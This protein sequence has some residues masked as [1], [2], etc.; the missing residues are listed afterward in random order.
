[1][2]NRNVFKSAL[3]FL[4][5][6]A[7]VWSLAACIVTPDPSSSDVSPSSDETSSNDTSDVGSSDETTS[8]EPSSSEE[9]TSSEEPASSEEQTSS[10]EPASSEEQTS[11]ETTSSE[12]TASSQVAPETAKTANVMDYG[13][14]GNGKADDTEAIA[15]AIKAAA[16]GIVVFPAGTYKVTSLTFP[17]NVVPS[18]EKG[19]YV[20]NS[21]VITVDSYDIYSG[22]TA[23]FIGEGGFDGFKNIPTV[24]VKWFGAYGD[25]KHDDTYGVQQAV[26]YGTNVY[27]PAGTYKITDSVHIESRKKN[28]AAS[29]D[30]TITGESRDKTVFVVADGIKGFFGESGGANATVVFDSVTI[31]GS[32]RSSYGVYFEK[33]KRV[34]VINSRLEGLKWGVYYTYAGDCHF[35]NN[36]AENND[37][38]YKIG[39][40]SMF[41]YYEK[42]TNKNNGTFIYCD[43]PESGGVSN[44]IMISD[45]VSENCSREDIYITRNQAVEIY[46]C[47][48][49]G[50]TGGK[51]AIFITTSCDSRI[52][53]NKITSKGSSRDGI[54]VTYCTEMYIAENDVTSERYAFSFECSYRSGTYV[55]KNTFSGTKADVGFIGQANDVKVFRNNLNSP[56]AIARAVNNTRNIL[57][58]QNTVALTYSDAKD[59]LSGIGGIVGNNFYSDG[60]Y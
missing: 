39:E 47:T 12:E 1:M 6:A 48:F 56:N 14:K 30:T 16:G 45:C 57:F 50:G 13:A 33:A 21:G 25:G 51:A 9:Q 17:E 52:M 26:Y 18:F 36:I 49:T 10:E 2:K 43:V 11:S 23:V 31:K 28:G 44:G 4:L 59:G 53:N 7:L 41:L 40:M 46:D 27:A 20:N 54:S 19:A 60:N 5:C 29:Y 34:D 8:V 22:G 38:V 35:Y 55:T 37:I 32:N 42:L 3:L 15:K 58:C 24:N